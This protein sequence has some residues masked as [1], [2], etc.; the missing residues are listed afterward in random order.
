MTSDQSEVKH[1]FVIHKHAKTNTLLFPLT[2]PYIV[3]LQQMA[4]EP[5]QDI[6]YKAT[7][8]IR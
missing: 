7:K 3:V 1:V 2:F 5:Y 8:F 6:L 4:E